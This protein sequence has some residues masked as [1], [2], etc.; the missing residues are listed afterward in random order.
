MRSLRFGRDDRSMSFRA[1][2]ER[3]RRGSREISKREVQFMRSLHFGRDDR[4][5]LL[6]KRRNDDHGSPFRK[7]KMSLTNFTQIGTF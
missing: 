2:S 3:R 6:N 1:G 5:A 7:P 4:R